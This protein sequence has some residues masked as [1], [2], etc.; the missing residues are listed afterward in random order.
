RASLALAGFAC[1]GEPRSRWRASLA[2]ASL[3]RVGEPRSRRSGR[4]RPSVEERLVDRLVDAP[5]LEGE[6][7]GEHPVAAFFRVEAAAGTGEVFAV[8]GFVV[9]HQH[10]G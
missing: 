2:L 10:R 4:P 5:R 6:R 9:D 1:A 7:G 8:E 3:A